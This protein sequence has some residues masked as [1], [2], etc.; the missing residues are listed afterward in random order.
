M[1]AMTEDPAKMTRAEALAELQALKNQRWDTL[2]KLARKQIG[3]KAAIK[4]N[5]K[6]GKRERELRAMLAHMTD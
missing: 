5:D 6:I 1:N 2:E 3:D 4:I